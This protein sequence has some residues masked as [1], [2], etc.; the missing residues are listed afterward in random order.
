MY[1]NNNHEKN[2]K[3]VFT[4]FKLKKVY[5]KE[6]YKVLLYV[7]NAFYDL[8]PSL[9]LGEW[10]LSKIKIITKRFSCEGVACYHKG[11]L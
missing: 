6:C 11:A 4:Y 5:F 9:L 2:L 3:H 7:Y 8:V 1:S 10:V